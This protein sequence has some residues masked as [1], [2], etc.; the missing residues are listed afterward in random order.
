MTPMEELK[1]LTGESNEE[2]LSL[3]LDAAE[4]V[5][6]NY[7]GRKI[8][9]ERLVKTKIKLALIAFNKLGMEGEIARSEGGISQTFVDIP[10]D[11]LSVLKMYRLAKVGGKTYEKT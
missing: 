8:L 3:L 4:D 6:I 11:I 5:V 2:L 1:K 7:T 9:P 10:E